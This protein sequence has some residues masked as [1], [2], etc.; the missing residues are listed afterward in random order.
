MQ[1]ITF[2]NINLNIK[3]HL[4]QPASKNIPDWYKKINSYSTGI[5]KPI[6]NGTPATIKR[7]MPVFDA[8]NAGYILFTPCDVWVSQRPK[9]E[10]DLESFIPY[11]E[12]PDKDYAA[13]EFHGIEQA[14]GHPGNTGHTVAL[15][16]WINNWTIATPKGY[17][18]IVVQ[19]WHRDSVFTILPAIVDTDTYN[20][21]INFPFV[22]NDIKFEGLIP[23][24]TPMAQII[25]FKREDWKMGLG[26]E[27]EILKNNKDRNFIKNKFFDG[28][29][30]FFRQKKEYK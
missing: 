21:T 13:I 27:S 30:D 25:P 1:N 19:P 18:I 11:F 26:K 15:P 4:P 14:L 7:C 8:L 6:P 20:H 17:S 2:T 28:Y 24:G 5:K 22:L 16:K 23:A 12:W 29:K 10:D 9:S 3:E